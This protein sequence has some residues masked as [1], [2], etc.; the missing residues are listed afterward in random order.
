M[1]K[2]SSLLDKVINAHN[3]S[4]LEV[5]AD[6]WPVLGQSGLHFRFKDSKDYI[7]QIVS[8]K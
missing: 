7:F 8:K 5:E 1:L 2:I 3:L 6:I 4:I